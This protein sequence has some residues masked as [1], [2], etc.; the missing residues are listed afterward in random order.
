[1]ELHFANTNLIGINSIKF[2]APFTPRIILLSDYDIKGITECITPVNDHPGIGILNDPD[3]RI[4]TQPVH[5]WF[6]TTRNIA[7]P[8]FEPFVRIPGSVFTHPA[9]DIA[10]SPPKHQLH[11]RF[12]EPHKNVGYIADLPEIIPFLIVIELRIKGAKAARTCFPDWEKFP[13]AKSRSRQ[14]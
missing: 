5:K 1:M 9:R 8:G 13:V 14:I 2:V 12:I 6:R 4:F 7:S 3:M 11:G 10:G